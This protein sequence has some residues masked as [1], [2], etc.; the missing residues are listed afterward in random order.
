VNAGENTIRD[1]ELYL[2][3]GLMIDGSLLKRKAVMMWIS[4]S[5][6]RL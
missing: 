5:K 6:V 1:F 4:M 2:G 3:D